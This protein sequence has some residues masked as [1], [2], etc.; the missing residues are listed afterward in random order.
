VGNYR[1]LIVGPQGDLGGVKTHVEMLRLALSSISDELMVCKGLHFYDIIKILLIYKPD[2]VIFN[3]SIYRNQVI[4]H[5][6]FRPFFAFVGA[7]CILHLHGGQFADLKTNVV[8]KWIMRYYFSTFGRIFCLTEE[9]YGFVT[10]CTKHGKNVRKIFNY[11]E[12][13][14][15]VS[16]KR[17]L[18][19]INFLFVGRLHLEKGILDVVSA[20]QKINSTNIRL[21]IVGDG[22]L[23]K[24]I[25]AVKDER[26]I[27][28]GKLFGRKK[29]EI[30]QK[31]HVFVMPSWK[32]GLP[33]VLLEAAAN[34]LALVSSPVGA[35]DQ[36]LKP[37]ANGYFVK[38]GNAVQLVNVLQELIDNKKKLS[39]MG[40]ASRIIVEDSF[41]IEK[42]KEIYEQILLHYNS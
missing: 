21:Y 31:S 19:T 37:G 32:E 40:T 16:L 17:N 30:F 6:V 1:I 34:G 14:S 35:I 13:P 26:I 23:E 24:D 18:D 41:S 38:P 9:Q 7:R 39:A 28:M 29:K 42:L 8:V 20:F 12:L 2:L 3:L 36:V 33:Y 4:K 5:I 11:V 10:D 15:K 25:R 22:E 27:Y